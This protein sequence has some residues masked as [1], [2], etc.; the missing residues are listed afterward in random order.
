MRFSSNSPFEVL[1]SVFT[2]LKAKAFFVFS[3]GAVVC[4]RI[5]KLKAVKMDVVMIMMLP[6]DFSK[7][8]FPPFT[9]LRAIFDQWIL[10]GRLGLVC[11]GMYIIC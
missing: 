1:A 8:Y 10:S 7:A 5:A 3:I 9:R 11:L 2:K 6:K 4:L